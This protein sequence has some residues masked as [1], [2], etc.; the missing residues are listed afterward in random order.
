MSRMSARFIG[1]EVGLTPA[2]VYDLLEKLGY[3]VKNKL[4]DWVLTEIGRTH[5]GKMSS[6]S[7]VS[8]PTFDLDKIESALIQTFTKHYK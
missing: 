8:V 4:G 7:R 1:K 3:V 2:A 6:G 5:G